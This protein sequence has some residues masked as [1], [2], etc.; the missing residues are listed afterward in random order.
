[1][2]EDGST[3]DEETGTLIIGSR[4]LVI[5]RDGTAQ[6]IAENNLYLAEP[7]PG[8][9]AIK[10]ADYRRVEWAGATFSED[11]KTL[12]VNIQI[13]GVTFAI[14]GPWPG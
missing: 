13:P 5:G 3:V 1:M 8:K 10:P 12:Y 9:P 2:C 4:L 7:I 6:A 14:E 11:G